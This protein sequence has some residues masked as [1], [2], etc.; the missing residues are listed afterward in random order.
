MSISYNSRCNL[1][2][3]LGWPSGLATKSPSLRLSAGGVAPWGFVGALVGAHAQKGVFV[4]TA[5]F[6]ASA[7]DLAAQDP[8]RVV[9]CDVGVRVRDRTG[10]RF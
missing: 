10:V 3:K 7:K 2:W 6:T 5:D 4:T 8:K 1:R 9:R